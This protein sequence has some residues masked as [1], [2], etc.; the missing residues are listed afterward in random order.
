MLW[1]IHS[2]SCSQDDLLSSLLESTPGTVNPSSSSIGA[3]L[4]FDFDTNFHGFQANS[5]HP[6]S[7]VGSDGCASDTNYSSLMNGGSPLINGNGG[8]AVAPSVIAE[9]LSGGSPHHMTESPNHSPGPLI[10]ST[11]LPATGTTDPSQ[12][13]MDPSLDFN[14]FSGVDLTN[15]NVITSDA[16]IT[17][18]SLSPPPGPT[19]NIQTTCTSSDVRINVGK[20]CYILLYYSHIL[21]EQNTLLFF[22]SR[23]EMNVGVISKYTHVQVGSLLKIYTLY[24]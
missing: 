24:T 18:T 16:T 3:P 9:S 8:V 10:S 13:A 5:L 17:S 11:Q 4:T 1:P 19:H 14:D 21:L 2:L 6:T 15:L 7:P 12:L 22:F 23:L 20:L